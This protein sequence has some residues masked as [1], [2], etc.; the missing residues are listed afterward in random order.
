M[1][2]NENSDMNKEN[3]ERL[4]VMLTSMQAEL[5]TIVSKLNHIAVMDVQLK[6]QKETTD[7]LVIR[8]RTIEESINTTRGNKYVTERVTK[9]IAAIVAAVLVY[10]VT[11]GGGKI[12]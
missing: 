8:V 4:W 3:V 12:L 11:T 1:S 7:D 2:G 9:W 5:S 6:H 10:M